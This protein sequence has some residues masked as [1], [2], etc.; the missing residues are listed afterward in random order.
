MIRI[1]GWIIIIKADKGW[2]TGI[3]GWM[4]RIKG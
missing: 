1:K 4:I 3:T 2:I